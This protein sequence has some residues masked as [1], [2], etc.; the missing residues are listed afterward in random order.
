[1]K[2]RGLDGPEV[3]IGEDEDPRQKLVD[4]M[5]APDNPFFARAIANRLWA[6]FM[7]RGLVEPVDDMRV[8]NPPSNP[9]LLDALAKDFVEHKF[10]LKHLIRTIMNST[11]YQ[12]SSEPTAEN[13]HD[14]QNYARA[15]PRRLLGRGDARRDLPGDRHARELRRPAQGDAGDRAARRV[16]RLVLPRR[17]RPADA[18]DRLRVRAAARGEPGPGAAPAELDR[19]PEQGRHA[20]GPARRAAQGEEDATRRS[21]RNCTCWR[22]A[23]RRGRAKHETVLAYVA[24]PDRPQ[25]RRSKTCSGRC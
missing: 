3:T 12:L 21:S 15:Y 10:D 7:G 23:G 14:R 1:M 25:G 16:G 18:R 2:P 19:H 5:A 4:W 6:H 8:T 24:E 9:E 17:L 22:S 11:A 13:V 20:Q